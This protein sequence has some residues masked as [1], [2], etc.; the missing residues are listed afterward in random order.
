MC[1]VDSCVLPWGIQRCMGS[2]LRIVPVAYPPWVQP[3]PCHASR[4]VLG[5]AL[6][7]GRSIEALPRPGGQ[8]RSR[9]V[10]L[11]LKVPV[12][13]ATP[14]WRCP[15]F[16]S[17]TRCPAC[18]RTVTAYHTYCPAC[19]TD[20]QHSTREGLGDTSWQCPSP[21]HLYD[22]GGPYTFTPLPFAPTPPPS[23]PHR[24]R[25]KWRRWR[26]KRA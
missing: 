16:Q 19:G 1:P 12:A 14:E 26:Q 5:L 21:V 15:M 13:N 6:T 22:E 3:A 4:A 9:S 2:S 24:L 20:L 17:Q 8:T 18:G 23:W 11:N 10:M 25:K 7:G